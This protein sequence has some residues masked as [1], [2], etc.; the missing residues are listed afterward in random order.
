MKGKSDADLVVFLAIN[1]T[2][3]ELQGSLNDILGRMKYYLGKYGECNVEG[4]TSHAVK[5]SVTCHGHSHDVDILP[6]VDILRKS[7]ISINI[8][9]FLKLLCNIYIQKQK[10]IQKFIC[11]NSNMYKL[12]KKKKKAQTLNSNYWEFIMYIIYNL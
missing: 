5:V 8:T 12:K 4:T 1:D 9:K 2:I 11:I 3:S 10:K 6:S 7:K